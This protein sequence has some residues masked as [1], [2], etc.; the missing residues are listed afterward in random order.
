MGGVIHLETGSSQICHL[1]LHAQVL[2]VT[3]VRVQSV[4]GVKLCVQNHVAGIVN[5]AGV[6]AQLKVQ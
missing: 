6:N 2:W 1:L 3:G 5:A 4:L